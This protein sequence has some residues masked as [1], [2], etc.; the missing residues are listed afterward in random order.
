MGWHDMMAG[1]KVV[2]RR[3]LLTVGLLT[4]VVLLAVN[5]VAINAIWNKAASN[6]RLYQEIIQDINGWLK[7]N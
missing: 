6:S 2:A 1:S 4:L 3:N 7:Y 5:A